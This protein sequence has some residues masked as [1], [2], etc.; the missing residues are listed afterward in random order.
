MLVD[1]SVGIKRVGCQGQWVIPADVGGGKSIV[2]CPGPLLN[3][4][5]LLPM[6]GVH[7]GNFLH[8]CSGH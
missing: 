7:C 4:V 8:N 6:V 1:V 5:V 3:A 2:F